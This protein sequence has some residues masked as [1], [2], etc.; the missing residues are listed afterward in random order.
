MYL[1]V[2]DDIICLED[3]GFCFFHNGELMVKLKKIL[4]MKSFEDSNL[5]I[6]LAER[7]PLFFTLCQVTHDGIF[8]YEQSVQRFTLP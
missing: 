6:R 4:V 7:Y 8:S 1:K 3:L 5:A 2:K